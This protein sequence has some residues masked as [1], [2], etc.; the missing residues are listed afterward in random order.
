[1]GLT[2]PLKN[3][4]KTKNPKHYDDLNRAMRTG[5]QKLRANEVQKVL[6]IIT[7]RF[8]KKNV[9]N[10]HDFIAYRH[11]ILEPYPFV[12]FGVLA[13]SPLRDLKTFVV[14]W[15]NTILDPR[16][17]VVGQGGLFDLGYGFFP[18]TVGFMWYAK[19][20][21]RYAM[22]WACNDR[23]WVLSSIRMYVFTCPFIHFRLFSSN[24]HVFI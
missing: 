13:C 9:S 6:Q 14:F 11:M 5:E 1:M 16:F 23:R 8:P 17:G 4:S 18:S 2:Q 3:P 20:T 7:R 15:S 12:D 21:P 22:P 24:I 19:M 10:L